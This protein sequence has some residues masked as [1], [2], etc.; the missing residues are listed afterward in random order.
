M[1]AAPCNATDASECTVE[2][3]DHFGQ[4]E[5]AA[6]G[7]DPVPDSDLLVCG[8]CG[9]PMHYDYGDE[10]YHHDNPE[11]PACFLIR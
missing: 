3:H 2:A 10:S 9:A 5:A 8:D 11:A 7:G 6:N 4:I 1:S